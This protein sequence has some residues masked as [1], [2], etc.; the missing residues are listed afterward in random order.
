VMEW[1]T[2]EM[3]EHV[4]ERGQIPLDR[5][6]RIFGQICDAVSYAHDNGII[7][8]DI[9][10]ANVFLI[11]NGRDGDRIK[12]IDFGMARVLSSD[13]GTTVTRFLGTYQYCSPEHFGG[14]VSSR[15]DVYSLGATLYHM[16][17]GTIPFGGSYINAKAHPHLELP[18]VPSLQRMR[19]GLPREVDEVLQKALSKSPAQRQESARQLFEEFSRACQC[20]LRV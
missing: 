15:S 14:K 4:I 13:T 7:H 9:K 16:L 6:T 17:A 2:G 11:G 18:P 10:P 8:L 12:V 5:L 3:L 20:A 19:P 1:L